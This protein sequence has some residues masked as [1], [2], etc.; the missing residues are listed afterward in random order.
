MI[1][2]FKKCEV[3][4]N[5]EL[6]PKHVLQPEVAINKY[7]EKLLLRH[8]SILRGIPITFEILEMATKGIIDNVTM[9]IYLPAKIRFHLLVLNVNDEVECTDGLAL[10]LFKTKINNNF[11]YNGKI[12]IKSFYEENDLLKIEGNEI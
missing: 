3:R 8:T 2:N 9:N 1:L 11:N 10:G 4:I 5:I 12:L 7:L 6:N